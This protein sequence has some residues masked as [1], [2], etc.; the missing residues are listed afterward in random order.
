VAEL[1]PARKQIKLPRPRAWEFDWETKAFD[2][3]ELRE[4]RRNMEDAG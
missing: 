1:S 2:G 4:L 3:N